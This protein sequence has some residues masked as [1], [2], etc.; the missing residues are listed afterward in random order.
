MSIISTLTTYNDRLLSII[1]K[2]YDNEIIKY[3]NNNNNLK[4]DDISLLN[5]LTCNIIHS[6]IIYKKLFHDFKLI[7][8]DIKRP[9]KIENINVLAF[10]S[11]FINYPEIKELIKEI[12]KFNKSF[13]KSSSTNEANLSNSKESFSKSELSKNNEHLYADPPIKSSKPII[14][15]DYFISSL[16]GSSSTAS[17]S[18]PKTT[19]KSVSLSKPLVKIPKTSTISDDEEQM[20][21]ASIKLAAKRKSANASSSENK[22]KILKSAKP[23]Y[24]D[25]D[26]EMPN[27]TIKLA[28]KRKPF[29][30][31]NNPN[32]KFKSNSDSKA[33]EPKFK[34]K[35]LG[36]RDRQA[37]ALKLHGAET[38]NISALISKKKPNK[39][40]IQ[41]NIV[42]KKVA[43]DKP[44]IK[45]ID[46][47]KEVLH[48]SWGAKRNEK[49]IVEFKGTRVVF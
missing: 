44:V 34:K 13:K 30:S 29:D 4:S 39:D 27:S 18:T 9:D 49:N 21:N 19:S 36:Q 10:L 15:D 40:N 47:D 43:K 42:N 46:L 14:S 35:R 22:T 17:K 45:E 11:S 23:K 3:I 38:K 48:P 8:D 32:K 6:Y 20:P 41:E 5:N 2:N 16:K 33:S 25:D 24:D 28:G 31:D 26:Q 7:I 12:M 37:L 1:N